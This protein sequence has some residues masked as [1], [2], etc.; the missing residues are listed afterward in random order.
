LREHGWQRNVVTDEFR[1]SPLFW[2]ELGYHPLAQPPRTLEAA[3]AL[4]HPTDATV[5][6]EEV[7]LHIRSQEPFE[8]EVRVRAADG[9]WRFVRARGCITEWRN[10][11]P[12]A[13]GGILNDIT[14]EVLEARIQKRARAMV[15][16]L[17]RRERQVLACLLAGAANKNIAGVFGL[18]QRTVEGYRARLMEKLNVQSVG[19]LV[20]IALAAG[21][22]A[23]ETCCDLSAS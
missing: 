1:V 4:L 3:R 20:T 14:N 8:I 9:A 2:D 5:A 15:A 16:V 22:A 10:Q 17:S 12:A 11:R 18:S 19:E 6:E 23:D 7:D 21:V 13:I